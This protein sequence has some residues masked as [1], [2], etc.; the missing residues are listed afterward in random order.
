MT[1]TNSVK[2]YK[3]RK[4]IAYLSDK[5]GREMEFIS[6]YIP[7]EK[8]I[9]EIITIL[10]EKFDSADIKSESVRDRV[11]N[12]LT[13]IMQ[14]LKLHKEIPENGLAIFAGTFA[15]NDPESESLNI[16]DQYLLDVLY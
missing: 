1:T 8:S 15:T 3:I 10:R 11:Q 4:L 5:E 9:D 6:L 7:R 14:Y 12:A 13:K 2:Q 16:R